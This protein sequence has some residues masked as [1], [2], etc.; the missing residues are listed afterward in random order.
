MADEI[1]VRT[2]SE[3]EEACATTDAIIKVDKDIVIDGRRGAFAT[4]FIELDLQGHALRSAYLT[5]LL[6]SAPPYRSPLIKNG[7]ILDMFVDGTDAFLGAYDGKTPLRF[8]NTSIS[9]NMDNLRHNQWVAPIYSCT[10][11]LCNI[12]VRHS[13]GLA[14]SLFQA[15]FTDSRLELELENTANG[16]AL[17]G[18][19]I[20]GCAVEG[21]WEGAMTGSPAWITMNNSVWNLDTQM[22]LNPDDNNIAL[23]GSGIYNADINP[24]ARCNDY[25]V[26]AR[27]ND[28]ILSPEYNNNNGFPVEVV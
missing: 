4:Q 11:N 23:N 13:S 20:N 28:S 7:R 3:F 5:G 2:L 16:S 18:L 26:L 10:F 6:F 24:F 19:S 25:T 27:N 17:N 21:H 1:I 22:L 9:V 8:E 12:F 14:R 15:S